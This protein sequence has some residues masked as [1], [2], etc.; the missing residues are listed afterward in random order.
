MNRIT[1]Y[2]IFTY[3]LTFLFIFNVKA[4]CSYQERKE[5]LNAAKNVDISVEP[6]EVSVEN[7]RYDFK[8]NIANLTNDIFIQYYNLNN[9]IENYISY[10]DLNNGLYSFVDENSLLI[11]NYKFIFYSNNDNCLGYE[12]TSKTLKKPMYNIYSENK[13]CLK[14]SNQNFKYCEKFLE[15]NYNLDINKF[16]KAITEYN[17]NKIKK[18]EKSQEETSDTKKNILPIS[19]SV[20]GII[21]VVIVIFLINKKRNKL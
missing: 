5:L 12:L 18:Q 2:I 19:L 14:E 16:N 9:G 7:G 15:K 8:F 20:V 6:V 3:F 11:Y 10:N 4:E 17:L 13:N 21:G 1:K